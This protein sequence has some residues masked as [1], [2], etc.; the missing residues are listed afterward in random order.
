MPQ[1]QSTRRVRHSAL[2]MLELVADVEKYPQFLPYC[3][4]S[5]IMRRTMAP[6]GKEIIL[7]TMTVGYGPI[8]E[9]FVSRA[10]IDRDRLKL[11]VQYVDG[12]FRRLENRWTFRPAADAGCDVDFFIDYA[13][14]SRTFELLAGSIFETLFRK[15]SDAFVE[16]ASLLDSAG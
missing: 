8:R 7:V 14:R 6:D 12:P 9:S 13:F 10:T 2:K 16:R 5:T 15:M 1:F 3:L 11:L 4:G